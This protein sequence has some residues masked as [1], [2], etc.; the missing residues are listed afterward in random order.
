[1]ARLNGNGHRNEM[2]ARAAE[3]A[4]TT[5]QGQAATAAVVGAAIAVA[6]LAIPVYTASLI[7][8][9]IFKMAEKASNWLDR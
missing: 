4:V 7:G 8:L 6:P 2:I 5:P 9:S 3:F 1:M